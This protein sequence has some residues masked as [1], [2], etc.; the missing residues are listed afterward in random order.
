VWREQGL[1]RSL[2]ARGTFTAANAW[3]LYERFEG[4]G[5]WGADLNLTFSTPWTK[6]MVSR[7]GSRERLLIKDGQVTGC[8]SKG[9]TAAPWPTS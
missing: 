3:V 1:P 4:S 8:R 6:G 9:R 5:L 2:L 7:D